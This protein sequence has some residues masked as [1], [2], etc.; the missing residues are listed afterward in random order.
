MPSSPSRRCSSSPASWSTAYVECLSEL[1]SCGAP[2]DQNVVVPTTTSRGSAP[3][4]EVTACRKD[5]S[6][7]VRVADR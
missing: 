4:V 3:S 5:A 2:E 1:T 6:S 7:T